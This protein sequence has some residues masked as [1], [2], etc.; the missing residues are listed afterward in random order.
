MKKKSVILLLITGIFLTLISAG[1]ISQAEDEISTAL[2]KGDYKLLSK[3]FNSNIELVLPGHE[4]IY[5]KSQAEIIIKDFFEKHPVDSYTVQH[6]G[7]PDDAKY[8]IGMYK[9]GDTSYRIYY[10]LKKNGQNSYIH[11][12]RI[13]KE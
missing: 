11:L 4:N 13:E 9:S 10:L 1:N 6:S 8:S 7:G 3:F 2:K 12:L 5:S